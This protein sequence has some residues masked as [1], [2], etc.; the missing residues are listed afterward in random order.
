MRIVQ[1]N[2]FHYPYMGGIEY[3]VHEV[4]KGLSAKH[5]IIVLTSQL[6]GTSSEE[7]RDGYRIVRLRS[8]CF[9]GY[10]PPYVI[11]P[12]V[13]EALERL[14]PDVVDFHYRWAPS[15]TKAIRRY[16]GKW[17]FTFHNTYGEGEGFG[18]MVSLANDK[19]FCRHIRDRRV[20]CITEFI[21]N[22]LLRRGFRE[23]LLDVAPNGI[24]LQAGEGTEGDY[25]LFLGRLVGTKG[26]PYLVKAMSKVDGRLVIVGGGPDRERLERLA[27]S[28]GV[29]D[30]TEFTGKV[31]TER[32]T[33]L[34]S[35]CKVFVMPSLFESYGIAVTEAMV[36][37]KPVVASNV[38]G[39]PEVVGN[40]GILVP[41]R[42]SDA[43][44][45]ALNTML[46]DDGLRRSYARAARQH[47]QRFSW[48]AI[49]DDLEAIY[50]RAA[51]D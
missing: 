38:G 43:L 28:Q 42:D 36:W 29:K 33:E 49:I 47:M 30:K 50:R 41:P 46:Q 37:G 15:Y 44:A 20:I 34:L 6:S 21:K 25:I 13:L 51:E 9:G 19:L 5:E 35:N 2:P 10:N 45:T 14:E 12:G 32:K 31:S 26:L 4:A 24:E 16:R 11:T 17:V 1:L 48:P 3:R 39:L 7:E 22:D 8:K 27:V 18:R 23:E 40:G